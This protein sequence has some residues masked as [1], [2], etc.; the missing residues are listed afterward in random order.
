MS[1]QQKKSK[2]KNENKNNEIDK[3]KSFDMISYLILI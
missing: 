2:N 1:D 3:K